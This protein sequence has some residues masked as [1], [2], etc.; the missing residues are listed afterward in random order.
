MDQ[1]ETYLLGLLLI[2]NCKNETF[3]FPDTEASLLI[4][5]EVGDFLQV[6]SAINLCN[7]NRI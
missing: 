5:R 2:K 7:W 1:T 6:R 4:T 3:Q